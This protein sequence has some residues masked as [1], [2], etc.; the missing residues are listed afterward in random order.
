MLQQIV[1]YEI[2]LERNSTTDTISK[3][4]IDSFLLSDF[5]YCLCITDFCTISGISLNY[6]IRRVNSKMQL[7]INKTTLAEIASAFRNCNTEKGFLLGSNTFL[8][9]ISFSCDLPA[10]DASRHYYSPNAN[11]ANHIISNWAAYGICFCGMVHSHLVNKQYLTENDIEYA[12]ALYTAY[13]LPILWF[14]IG[15]IKND[16]VVFKFYSV[17]ESDGQVNISPIE[18][19]LEN[20]D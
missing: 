2:F 11:F 10:S 13:N 14:G 20:N 4:Q 7:R 15:V 1:I 9:Y 16:N 17:S 5:N 6:Q 18:Y 3:D 8:N 12:K 19:Y